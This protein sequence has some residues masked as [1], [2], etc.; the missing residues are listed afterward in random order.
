VSGPGRLVSEES[1]GAWVVKCDPR[2]NPDVPRAARSGEPWVAQRWCVADN[3]RSR[4]M[5]PGHRAVLWVSGDGRSL[6]RGLWGLGW[7]TGPVRGPGGEQ[8]DGADGSAGSGGSGGSGGSA[9]RRRPEV[10]LHLPLARAGVSPDE[11]RAAGV[12]DL[13]VLVQPHGSNPS[14]ISRSQLARL[15]PLL[16]EWPAP[17]R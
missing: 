4:M 14:W 5:R 10:A 9:G 1:L 8:V 16:P 6:A 12:A 2:A 13:E 17:P 3:Y 11:I 15:S 7:V